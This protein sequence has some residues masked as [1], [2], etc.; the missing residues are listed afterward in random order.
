MTLWFATGNA[1]KKTEL[2]AILAGHRL[3]TPDE[4][5][6][7]FDPEETG[8]TFIDNALLMAR[9]LFEAVGEPTVADDSGLCVDA[10]GGRPGIL[11]ARYGSENGAKLDS[12]ARNALL[13]KEIGAAADRRARFVCALVAYFGPDRFYA[14]QETC[15]G[16]IL[17][18]PRGA[19]GFGY[20]PILYLPERACSVAELAEADKNRISHRAK[21]GRALAA[22]LADLR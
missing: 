19:G 10:L 9:A 1:H 8:A 14:V 11:S 12:A 5:G 7:A 18:A 20:D 16:E 6:L 3:R 4:I 21:A 13:L 15:E 2:S 22:L 17:A